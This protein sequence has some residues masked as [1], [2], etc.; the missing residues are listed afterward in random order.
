MK[1]EI[2]YEKSVLCLKPFVDSVKSLI[3]FHRIVSIKGYKVRKGLDEKTDGC[4]WVDDKKRT[5]VVT[6]LT[7]SYVKSK[8][9]HRPKT[10]HYIL[11]TLA[12]EL[13]HT[14]HWEHT[15]KHYELNAKIALKFAKV[16][17]R[18]GIKDTGRRFD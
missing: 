7:Y 12:H 3:P 16:I 15:Y 6:L 8:K 13:A 5:F 4:T 14:V 11:D 9:E 18:L 10:L 17:K 1:H 2:K